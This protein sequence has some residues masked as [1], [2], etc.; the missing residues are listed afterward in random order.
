A[1]H[2]AIEAEY[3]GRH[4]VF[5]L[6]YKDGAAAYQDAYH[7]LVDA[8]QALYQVRVPLVEPHGSAVAALLG[9]VA[10][11]GKELTLVGVDVACDHD[12]RVGI[13]GESPCG[14]DV[15]TVIIDYFCSRHLPHQAAQRR[16]RVIGMDPAGTGRWSSRWRRSYRRGP[17]G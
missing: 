4:L 13:P 8:F 14:F 3:D 11:V 2:T 7:V 15:G 17:A 16:N 5:P 10:P 6:V 9:Y 12:H 1:F